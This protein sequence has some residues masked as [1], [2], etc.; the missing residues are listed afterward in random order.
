MKYTSPRSISALSLGLG[1][2]TVGAP[3]MAK[4]TAQAASSTVREP[5]N[6]IKG[7]VSIGN[8]E[9]ARVS[10]MPNL[11]PAQ[12]AKTIA[13]RLNALLKNNGKDIRLGTRA[14]NGEYVVTVPKSL[15]KTGFV[16]TADAHY[17]AQNHTT[18]LA[19]ATQ[20]RNSLSQ[21]V[22]HKSTPNSAPLIIMGD[23]ADDDISAVDD[24]HKGLAA[25]SAGNLKL[26]EES[27]Q[28]A[29]KKAQDYWVAYID[30]CNVQM[31]RG[32]TSA[33]RVTLKKVQNHM[34]I[35]KL[36]AESQAQIARLKKKLDVK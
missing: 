15:V 27:Y 30:L 29:T 22:Q 21:L 20:L 28:N 12:R 6:V 25:Y 34:D 24:Y 26:A 2:L 14:I 4:Q 18:S 1:L 23:G 32:E 35:T 17:A 7:R 19:L 10:G 31:E 33:A 3:S 11:S 9:F 13:A 8:Q 5:G 36:D 16:I